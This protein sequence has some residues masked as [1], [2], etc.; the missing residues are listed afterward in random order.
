MDLYYHFGKP[1]SLPL[2]NNPDDNELC[3]NRLYHLTTALHKK[4]FTTIGLNQTLTRFFTQKANRFSINQYDH[5]IARPNEDIFSND[6][7]NA[8]HQLT[9]KFF[10]KSSYIFT[11][12][13]LKKYDH[14]ISAALRDTKAYNSYFSKLNHFSLT[15]NFL[16]PKERDIHCSHQIM[17]RT[18]QTYTYTYYKLIQHHYTTNTRS[19]NPHHRFQSFNFKYTSPFLL[20]FTYCIKDTNMQGLLRNYECMHSAH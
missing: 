4:Q 17:L 20:N 16:T 14:I 13:C 5:A 6:D 9:E 19:R 3:Q 11:I 15:F 12:N 18:K 7:T 1:L 10:I 2:Y 8:N